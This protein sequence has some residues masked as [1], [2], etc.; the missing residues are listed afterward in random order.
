MPD[1]CRAGAAAGGQGIAGVGGIPAGGSAA[2]SLSSRCR[3]EAGFLLPGQ[4]RAFPLSAAG[5]S[6]G[7]SPH[8]AGHAMVLP[9][10][11]ELNTFKVLPASPVGKTGEKW[12]AGLG[13]R[14]CDEYESLLMQHQ[15]QEPARMSGMSVASSI[16]RPISR[17]P[18]RSNLG[19][20]AGSQHGHSH[21]SGS[22]EVRHTFPPRPQVHE[23]ALRPSPQHVQ[24]WPILGSQHV[25]SKP[26]KNHL[27]WLLPRV[28]S[29]LTEP[30]CCIGQCWR[31]WLGSS[32]G[33]A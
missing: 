4:P 31:R 13:I 12:W 9:M 33:C 30:A 23:A 2:R 14:H 25:Q 7:H 26:S 15:R 5:E 19:R 8:A 29:S 20:S 22:E 32:A 21:S 27:P 24:A 3:V 10:L 28:P 11:S 17:A 6:P 18:S 1:S 16:D